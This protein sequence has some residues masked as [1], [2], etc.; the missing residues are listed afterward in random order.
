MKTEQE[1]LLE[2][3]RRS[4]EKDLDAREELVRT[5]QNRVY[6]HCKKMLKNKEDAEDTTQTV[7]MT[8]I[9]SLDKLKEPAAFW[10]WVNGI[11]A[12]QCKHLLTAPHKEWQ[13]PE[14]E[15]GNSMLE[16]VEN[17]DETL[18]PEKVLDNEE[19]RR[20]VLGLVNELP[21][22]QRMT[23]LFYYYDEM[24]VKQIAE[25]MDTSEGTVKSRLNYARKSIKAGV[26]DYERKGAKLYGISPLVLLVFF[27]RQEAE[28]TLLSPAAAAAMAGQVL[29]QAGS[30]AVSGGAAAGG[31]GAAAEGGASSAGG[32]ASAAAKAGAAAGA[33]VKAGI[34]VK[35]IAGIVAAVIVVSGAAIG[36]TSMT[37]QDNADENAGDAE[38][39]AAGH[40]DR[41]RVIALNSISALVDIDGSLW[42]WGG[43]LIDGSGKVSVTPVKYPD[44]VQ[45]VFNTG[46]VQ[47][48]H[49]MWLRDENLPYRL[50]GIPE[51]QQT[52]LNG[53]F[54]E[55]VEEVYCLA[56]SYAILKT[57]GSL[58]M[59]GEN[60]LGQLGT[61]TTGDIYPPV[62]V[63]ENVAAFSAHAVD[64]TFSCGGDCIYAAVQEDG[65]LWLWG[66]N[67]DDLIGPDLPDLVTTPV[68][69]MEDVESVCCR[70]NAIVVLKE[71]NTVWSW[72]KENLGTGSWGLDSGS[73]V[74]VQI[75][76]QVV[77]ISADEIAAA[78]RSDGTLWTW[79]GYNS[80]QLGIGDRKN[81]YR[82]MKIMDHV[83]DVSCG[84]S[85]VL[86]LKDD[87]TVW[88]WGSNMFGQLGSA[89]ISSS[90]VPVQVQ[91]TVE[92]IGTIPWDIS[93]YVDDPDFAP[94][95]DEPEKSYPE[96]YAAYLTAL[97]SHA[98]MIDMYARWYEEMNYAIAPVAFADVYGDET[99]EI[100]FVEADETYPWSESYL[101]ILTYQDGQVVTLLRES[102]DFYA[103][104]MLT[105]TLFQSADGK[106]L[107]ADT[108]YSTSQQVTELYVFSESGGA[109]SMDRVEEL[110][111]KDTLVLSNRYA[112]DTAM[113][114]EEAAAFL[115]EG[116]A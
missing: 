12:N 84:S 77:A 19:T 100:L 68:K 90:D 36:I 112:V 105:Y 37:G 104:S 35:L 86:A 52:M 101:T 89:A 7:L 14:D 80:S 111:G 73:T 2:L 99:P 92:D 21:P 87:G 9:A 44:R 96:A 11:T 27:L 39:L 88:A 79:G 113:T 115:T 82:P 94:P 38:V 41:A 103:G 56:S 76:T 102:W 32:A 63:M 70:R 22:E 31:A 62:N 64:S 71:D 91:F 107:Y 15:E 23:V 4:R 51:D 30:G 43:H 6:Y 108:S 55:D 116:N 28:G 20:M 48:D 69:V 83:V 67:C 72:G 110:P 81:T 47:F 98:E 45:T 13:I 53:K 49:S 16:S 57:D 42:T 66:C 50:D 109:L 26:E 25:A 18:V 85:H 95:S 1:K 33:A 65:S 59:M 54:M 3:I 40:L 29:S 93:Q 61:G 46:V 114:R 97:D 24:S 58:W 60:D 74:P 34:S 10:A 106:T 5:V 8:M 78:I 17:L 75:M